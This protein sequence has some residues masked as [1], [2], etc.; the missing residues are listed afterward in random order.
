MFITMQQSVRPYGLLIPSRRIKEGLRRKLHSTCLEKKLMKKFCEDDNK[1][2]DYK[3]GS[4][5]LDQ[6][7]YQTFPTN[8]L[9]HAYN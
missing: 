5:F 9:H 6:P 8:M 7:S 2:F 4:V 1:T 3:E